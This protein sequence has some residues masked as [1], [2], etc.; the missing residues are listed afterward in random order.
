MLIKRINLQ[1]RFFFRCLIRR[2]WTIRDIKFAFSLFHRRVFVT[3]C[4]FFAYINNSPFK[5]LVY[6][7][8][9]GYW[10]D[11]EWV[12]GITFMMNGKVAICFT[13]YV[14]MMVCLLLFM[15]ILLIYKE[16]VNCNRKCGFFNE[17]SEFYFLFYVKNERRNW[18]CIFCVCAFRVSL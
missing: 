18:W 8:N 6:I 4:L 10:Y 9:T 17:F 1:S 7:Q 13:F 16:S 11:G 3:R 5:Y 12:G 15:F 2:K 14:L